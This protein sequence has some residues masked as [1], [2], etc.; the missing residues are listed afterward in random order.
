MLRFVFSA[1]GDS[2]VNVVDIEAQRGTAVACYTE[3]HERAVL[4]KHLVL[5]EGRAEPLHFTAVTASVGQGP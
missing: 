3:Q 2:P 4:H 5:K 1:V